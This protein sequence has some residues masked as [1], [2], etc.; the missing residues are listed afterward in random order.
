MARTSLEN[1]YS[2]NGGADDLHTGQCQSQTYVKVAGVILPVVQS[3][4][5][6]ASFSIS[7]H[8]TAIAKSPSS[9][10]CYSLQSESKTCTDSADVIMSVC[11]ANAHRNFYS[12]NN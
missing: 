4:I 6:L 10:T 8:E 11:T 5:S 2:K 12:W 9:A 3:L 1:E 7:D